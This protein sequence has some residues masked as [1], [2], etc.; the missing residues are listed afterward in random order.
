MWC[1]VSAAADVADP[2]H[3]REGT[4]SVMTG[5]G[6]PVIPFTVVEGGEGGTEG[7]RGGG[8][9]V[10]PI[11]IHLLIL[12]TLLLFTHQLLVAVS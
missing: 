9:H 2:G 3:T 12:K 6:H 4:V 7:G 11:T 5:A 8:E 10:M 1:L